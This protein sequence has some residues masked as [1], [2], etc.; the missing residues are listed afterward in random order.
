MPQFCASAA[1]RAP[2]CRRP[3]VAATSSTWVMRNTRRG[4]SHSFSD[5]LR[6][7]PLDIHKTIHSRQVCASR[8]AGVSCCGVAW[9]G[10][11]W[12][13]LAWPGLA[14]R[15]LRKKRKQRRSGLGWPGLAWP[16]VV[17]SGISAVQEISSGCDS[18]GLWHCGSELV[19]Q[20]WTCA[21][22]VSHTYLAFLR[23]HQRNVPAGP[24]CRWKLFGGGRNDFQAN[25]DMR[26][27][28]I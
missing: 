3:V 20:P 16:A 22:G 7:L 26:S 17:L 1:D 9:P 28:P 10:L 25:S 4:P 19:W 14:W 13:S 6:P 24:C 8:F 5:N 15:G 12:S 18:P 27:L 11:A 21:S 2:L 23:D